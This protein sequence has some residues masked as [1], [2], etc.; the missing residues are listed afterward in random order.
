MS[1]EIKREGEE[2]YLAYLRRIADDEEE[3]ARFRRNAD[4]RGIIDGVTPDA[5][6]AYLRRIDGLAPGWLDDNWTEL[7]RNDEV[8]D[9]QLARFRPGTMAPVTLR[10]AWNALEM[11]RELSLAGKSVVEIGGG[12]GGLARLVCALFRPARYSI[13]D[14]PE[15]LTAA[16]RY[17]AHFDLGETQ[18]SFFPPDTIIEADVFVANYSVAEFDRAEQ[19]RYLDNVILRTR[20]G[21]LTHNIPHPSNRQMSRAEFEEELHGRFDVRS[22]D[23][24]LERCERSRVYVCREKN[25]GESV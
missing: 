25:V 23:E 9:P 16:A 17:L 10:Y 19:R 5:A 11:D 1:W 7:A 3:F 20:S 2:R 21:Y 4:V 12:Y 6:A 22:Y 8:G 14:V 24:R 18:V 15:A 13:I